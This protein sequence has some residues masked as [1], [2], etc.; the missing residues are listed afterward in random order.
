[1]VVRN[2]VCRPCFRGVD[3]RRRKP[4]EHLA[5]TD[6]LPQASLTD[7]LMMRGFKNTSLSAAALLVT[8][9]IAAQADLPLMEDPYDWRKVEAGPLDTSVEGAVIGLSN[10]CIIVAGGTIGGAGAS[11]VSSH[12][13]HFLD[14]REESLEW[15][16]AG[17]VF[18]KGIFFGLAQSPGNG[19]IC[20]GGRR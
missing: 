2:A 12:S 19:I 6:C 16:I 11:S 8:G 18:P 10:E 7:L 20:A 13:I 4:G 5:E 9:I 1:M 3:R 15:K 14:L 17:E